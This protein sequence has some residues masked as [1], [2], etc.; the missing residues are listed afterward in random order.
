MDIFFT[1]LVASSPLKFESSDLF[2]IPAGELR[3]L[4]HFYSVVLFSLTDPGRGS[5]GPC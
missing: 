2:G 3:L 5:R 1:R 4:R